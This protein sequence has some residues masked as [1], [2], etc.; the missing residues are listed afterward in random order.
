[1]GVEHSSHLFNNILSVLPGTMYGLKAMHQLILPNGGQPPHPTRYSGKL[2]LSP[3]SWWAGTA[4]STTV[5]LWASAGIRWLTS[6]S[7]THRY[8]NHF[9]FY[10]LLYTSPFFSVVSKSQLCAVH[11]YCTTI[12]WMS[13]QSWSQASVINELFCSSVSCSFKYLSLHW[14]S[15]R[16][17]HLKMEK[18]VY[19]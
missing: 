8:L 15:Q 13:L 2:T 5:D 18:S 1:M 17:Y 14:L 19:P 3:M 9:H 7:L 4:R 11:M 16:N 10:L 6:W 12:L